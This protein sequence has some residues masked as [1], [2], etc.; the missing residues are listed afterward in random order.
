[1]DYQEAIM[2]VS[3]CTATQE[4]DGWGHALE[5]TTVKD[6][7]RELKGYLDGTDKH[8][9]VMQKLEEQ[10]RKDKSTNQSNNQ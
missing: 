1:L 6:D 10:V 7:L 8:E 2:P 3:R 9:Q 4:E 5:S